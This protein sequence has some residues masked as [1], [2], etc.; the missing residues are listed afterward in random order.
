MKSYSLLEL[1]PKDHDHFMQYGFSNLTRLIY[2][3]TIKA[4]YEFSKINFNMKYITF[5]L[6]D[7]DQLDDQFLN[8]YLEYDEEFSNRH[9]QLGNQDNV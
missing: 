1:K 3:S 2:I 6:N 7:H 4:Y 8:L 9:G 5:Q